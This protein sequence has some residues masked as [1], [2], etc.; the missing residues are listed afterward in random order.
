MNIQK[1]HETRMP[2]C[3]QLHQKLQINWEIFGPQITFEIVAQVDKNDYI[4][5]G[6]SGSKNSSQMIGSDI[7]LSYLDQHLG[8]TQD[9]NITGKFPVRHLFP[10]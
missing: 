2:N 5:F 1:K 7:A 3:E 10:L 4:A 9:Y 8:V 6:I